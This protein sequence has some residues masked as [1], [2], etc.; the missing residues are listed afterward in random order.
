MAHEL[1]TTIDGRTAMAYTG[2]TPWHGLGQRLDENATIADW[3][4]AA[5]LDYTLRT[6]SVTNG[7]VTVPGKSIIYREDTQQGLSVVSNRYCVVQ[8]IQVLEFFER[9]VGGFAKIETAGVLFE[10]RRYWALARL[11]GEINV[12][13]DITR[14]YLMLASSCDGSLATQARLTSV[15]V[16]C[17]NTLQMSQQGSADVVI[18]HNSNFDA[19]A[20]GDKLDNIYE[21]LR[22]QS[23]TLKNL[24]SIQ[25]T[26]ARAKEFLAKLYGTTTDLN[27][28]GARI[29]QLFNGEAIGSEQESS[30]GTAYGLLQAATQYVDWEGGRKQDN[31]LQHAW[32][33]DGADFKMRVANDLLALATA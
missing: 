7:F 30:K 17:N 29:L 5:G 2:E 16:V 21:S 19:D 24:A 32:F 12:A 4:I 1:A 9:Y 22:V 31:R 28:Q 23:E 10:G 6:C 27:R 8:P 33:G 25:V 14:P 18:R 26:E 13:G 15:R 20:I 11:D 3:A